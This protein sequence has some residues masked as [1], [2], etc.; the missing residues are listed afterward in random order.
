ML[1]VPV[2]PVVEDKRRG[3][4]ELK[5]KIAACSHRP[6]AELAAAGGDERGVVS[7]RRGLAIID[8]DPDKSI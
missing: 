5:A 6:D 7:G 1:G 4:D 2:V 8:S 3:I